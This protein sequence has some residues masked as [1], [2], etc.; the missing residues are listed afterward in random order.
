[1]NKYYHEKFC[2]M[3]K[4]TDTVG[5]LNKIPIKAHSFMGVYKST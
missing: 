5:L 3:K 4:I 2:S 1:M